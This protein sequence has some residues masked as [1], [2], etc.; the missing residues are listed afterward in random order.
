M[1]TILVRSSPRHP[2]S[3]A[4]CATC[5]RDRTPASHP[6]NCDPSDM[7]HPAY[8]RASPMAPGNVAASRGAERCEMLVCESCGSENPDDV[9][10]C[11][12]CGAFLSKPAPEGAASEL[13]APDAVQP[14]LRE[15]RLEPFRPPR[16]DDQRS[17]PTPPPAAPAGPPD[18][19]TPPPP[20]DAAA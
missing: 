20:D 17:A 8:S 7:G 14:E 3:K 6:V 10:F 11:V 1:A 13:P 5:S 18:G 9:H 19:A 12:M 15:P 4:A 2:A 16:V